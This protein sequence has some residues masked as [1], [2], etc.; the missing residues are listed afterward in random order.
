MYYQFK[1]K[2]LYG[3][4]NIDKGDNMK[5]LTYGVPEELVPSKY[6]AGLNYTKT[7][8]K[9]DTDSIKFK[10]NNRG[11][12][13]TMPLDSDEQ[14]FGL[15]LQL[16]G[17][18][19]KGTKKLLRVN[20]DPV[21]NT[22][23]SHAPVPFFVTTKGYGIY[24]DTARC[25]DFYCGFQKKLD[26]KPSE[27]NGV[28][29][30]TEEL[31]A[32]N[33]EDKKTTMIIDIPTAKGVTIYIFEGET[34]TDIVS[35]YNMLS[36]G[37]A[38]V[39]DWG[40]GVF[41]RCYGKY[42]G[43]QVMETARYFRENDIP[44]SI[45][46]LEPGWQSS[47]YSCSYVWDKD[48]YPNYI[49]VVNYLKENGFEISLWE[50][51]FVNSS[52]PIYKD[53]Q[54]YS[55]EYEVWKGLVPDF[56]LEQARD[57]FAGH[58]K[59][60]LVDIGISGFKLDECD[61]SDYTGSWSFPNCAQFPSGLDGE[62]YHNLFGTFYMQVMLKALGDTKTLSEV[63]NAG[64]LA[65]SYP[66]VLYSDLYEHKDFIRGVVNSGFS[67][68][69]WT[70][71]VREGKTKND[72]IRRIQTVVFSVQCLINAWYCEKAPWLE[73]GGED[74]VRELFKVRERLIPMLKKAFLEYN[75][76][77]KPPVRAL[78]SDYTDDTN[79]YNIEDE[80]IFCDD[81]IVAPL[82]AE[83]DCRKVY[84][85]QGNWVD[86]WTKQPVQSGWFEVETLNIPVYEK[87]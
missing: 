1:V 52:S 43:D 56:G 20:A 83:S 19:H 12:T 69:L 29:T 35:Q 22:G 61:S 38:C 4:V 21:A 39:P 84:L 11:C 36:G 42:T 32:K 67:G 63:R 55:G 60:A 13:L 59:K 14:V 6:C 8:V 7:D 54:P 85:P 53:L 16:K 79:T 87:V 48:R 10:V 70:P 76:T 75:K 15:G 37:G 23:D 3:C 41:Y 51:A 26:R 27:N 18:N 50:H 33:L 34:I 81:L 17:F 2:I 25:V 77:G 64:A 47:T 45:L 73:F 65:S 24:I 44:C 46:G 30:T 71:E 68:L 86:Y 72:L 31:Y 74:E 66:F 57:I 78:V 80:Y 82:T 9:F 58:H 28:I 49:E 40:L 62:Q 5:R